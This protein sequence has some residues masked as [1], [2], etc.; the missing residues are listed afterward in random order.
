MKKIN[1]KKLGINFLL[2]IINYFENPKGEE[3]LDFNY[4]NERTDLINSLFE[5]IESILCYCGPHGIGKTI[6]FLEFKRL[7]K[8]CVILI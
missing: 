4:S 5:N 3:I 7:K 1:V 6:T 2:I 8:K